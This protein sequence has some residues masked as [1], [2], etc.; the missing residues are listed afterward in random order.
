M[1]RRVIQGAALV[2]LFLALVTVRVVH[3]SHAE[4]SRGDA[5]AD[6]DDWD[7]AII[8]WR[9]AAKWY[10]PG[11]PYVVTA[12]DRLESRA[13]EREGEGDVD[14][15]LV[16]WRA[17]RGSILASRHVRV[18]FPER[19]RHADQRIAR[20][21]AG[22]PAPPIDAGRS[23]DEL[24]EEHLA[25]LTDTPGPNVFF[26][27]LALLGFAGWVGGALLF[28]SRGLDREDRL[29]KPEAIRWGSL[30]VVGFVLFA[31]GLGLA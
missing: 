1:K 7:G 13:L 5:A 24:Y 23:E 14:A 15:A 3:S 8:H 26:A 9:R 4:L 22:L 2:A 19:R 16:A 20:L 11:N 30:V 21:M 12:L 6:A 31:L 25:L 29:I 18:P 17:V 10:A 27:L 28:A